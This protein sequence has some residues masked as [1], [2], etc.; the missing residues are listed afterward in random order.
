MEI[1]RFTIASLFAVC[2]YIIFTAI[3]FFYYPT[4]YSP[5]TNW[6]SDLG[7][8]LQNPSGA[9][10]YKIGGVLTSSALILFFAGM[11][12]WLNKDKRTNFFIWASI[13]SG[14][15]MA[16]AFIVTAL[17]PLGVATSIHSFFSILRFAFTGLFVTFSASAV[18]RM[19]SHI[20]W[21]PAFGIALAMVNF[22]VC[23]SFFF[24]NLYVGE[25]I[26]IALFIVYILTLSFSNKAAIKLNPL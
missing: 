15:L 1:K 24:V 23:I 26:T 16:V 18:R 2:L 10:Y 17:F 6:L 25:W 13:A 3:S 19:P 11:Y 9:I 14:I 5:M 4:A 7:N 21:L 8:P 20:R 22:A 12:S